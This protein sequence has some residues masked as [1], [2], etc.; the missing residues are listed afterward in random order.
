MPQTLNKTTMDSI[1]HN[2]G[3]V[4]KSFWYDKSANKT[5]WTL[6]TY[7][8]NHDDI[9]VE[10]SYVTMSLKSLIAMI[11]AVVGF[12]ASLSFIVSQYYFGIEIRELQKD[13]VK[14]EAEVRAR[15]VMELDIDHL[16]KQLND[17]QKKM[18]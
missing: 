14:A 1:Y 17:L 2:A 6:T 16:Q 4:L 10:T 13:L 12:S 9:N 5:P 18:K 11:I 8:K 7:K 15:K 3:Q